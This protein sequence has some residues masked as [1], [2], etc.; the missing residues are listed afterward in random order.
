MGKRLISLALVWITLLSLFPLAAEGAGEIRGY[1][2][3]E[4][5]QYVRFG[6]YFTDADGGRQ[7]VLWRVLRAQNG[8]AYLLSEYILFSGPV[9]G[10]ND[11]YDDW[12]KSDLY[13]YL[14]GAFLQDAFSPAQQAAL[15]IRTEDNARVTL[16]S[17][18]EMK[19][20]SLGF[21][22][23][24]SRQCQSTAWAKVLRDPPL[25]ELPKNNK[26]V[27][28]KKLNVFSGKGQYSPWWSRTRSADHPKE[29]RRVVEGGKIGRASSGYTDQG[30]RPLITVD[31]SRVTIASGTGAQGS[32]FLLQAQGEEAAAPAAAPAEAKETEN[33]GAQAPE[34]SAPAA[35][36]VPRASSRP[37]LVKTLQKGTN[38]CLIEGEN[39]LISKENNQP[40]PMMRS[41]AGWFN[42][43]IDALGE[44]R[45]PFYLYLVE[46][47]RS[48]DI[49]WDFDVD[50]P[51][52]RYLSSTLH[53]NKSD[54][55][56][57]STYEEFCNYFYSTDHH[58]N[59]K[60]SYQGYVDIVRMMLGEEEEVLVPVETVEIPVIYNGSY[61]NTLKLAISQEKFAFYRFDPF[62]KYTAYQYGKK[63]PY[64]HIQDI[65]LK[66]KYKKGKYANHYAQC[67]G[68][69]AGLMVFESDRHPE[70]TLLLIGNSLSNAVKFLLPYHFGRVVYVDLRNYK[71]QTK[72]DFSMSAVIQQY[73]VN[74]V[75]LLGDA[76]L[77][78][79]G[80]RPLP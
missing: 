5:Y 37:P 27:A 17:S 40:V 34:A 33:P 56:K 75:L 70:R 13:A 68:G 67:Y 50:S 28:W 49:D 57:Y 44:D 58:W 51:A 1:S 52:Y 74:Q 19:D 72:K 6:A 32:P 65:Y 16:L 8:E 61:A 20:D 54:H 11:H 71:S 36:P 9:Q 26:K 63:R 2:K 35:S 21:S 15:L 53:V 42:E 41:F 73:G 3:A 55:L 18:D 31:L 48:H 25:W 45:P 12:E 80:E 59:Y 66:G 76:Y 14:N 39:R 38:I 62:P 78:T 23:D 69:D 60:G 4:G 7:P 64:D 24:K 29:Q 77:F 43:A 30:A 10:D 79:A 47:S 22:S 46:S